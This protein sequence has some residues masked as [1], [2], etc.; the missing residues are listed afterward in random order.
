[1]KLLNLQSMQGRSVLAAVIFSALVTSAAWIAQSRVNQAE[2]QGFQNNSIQQVIDPLFSH[3]R[4]KFTKSMAYLQEFLLLPVPETR[5]KT[6]GLLQEILDHKGLARLHQSKRIDDYP[7]T[8]NHLEDIKVDLGLLIKEVTNLMDVRVDV[9]RLYPATD[10]NVSGLLPAN[11]KFRTNASLAIN[12]ATDGGGMTGNRKVYQ[13]FVDVR[14]AWRSMTGAYRLYVSNRS[15]LFGDPLS[16]MRIQKINITTYADT[17]QQMLDMLTTMD[18]AGELEFQQSDA[19]V[20]MKEAYQ[21]WF[22]HYSKTIPIYESDQWRTDIA[23]LRNSIQPLTD[24]IRGHFTAIEKD[25]GQATMSEL[26]SVSAIARS[27]SESIWIIV[28]ISIIAIAAGLIAIE[29][30]LRRPV[31]RVVQ[32]LKE[33]SRADTEDIDQTSETFVDSNTEEARELIAAFREMKS[34]VNSRQTR[35]HTILENAAEA[36]V[37][38]NELGIIESFNV[39]AEK[40]FGYQS[41]EVIGN[42]IDLLMTPD[43]GKQHHQFLQRYISKGMP[44]VIDRERELTAKHKDGSVLQISLKISEMRLEGRRLFNALMVDISERKQMLEL[45]QSRQKYLETILDNAAEGI[46]TFNEDGIIKSCNRAAEN[47]FGYRSQE[48]VNQNLSEIIPPDGRD[49]RDDYVEHFIRTKVQS[50]LGHEGEVLGRTQNGRRF[51]MAI[52]ISRIMLDNDPLYIGLISDISERKAIL[53]NLRKM[54]EYDGLTGLHN[55]SYFQEEL[56]QAVDRAKHGKHFSANLLYIDLDN[57]KYVNDTMG[58]AAGDQLLVE[59]ASM[60]NKRVRKADIVAR[61]GGDEFTVLLYDSDP[62]AA[63]AIAESFRQSMDEYRFMYRGT[64]VDIGCTIGVAS[65]DASCRNG[66]YAVSRADLACNIA[67]RAGRNRVRV[68]SPEDDASVA[69]LSVD[70]GWSAMI[71]E[72]L[73]HDKF[74]LFAQPIVSTSNM[75]TNSYEIL[76]R[77]IDGNGDQIMPAGFIPSAERFGLME[78]IDRWVIKNSIEALAKYRHYNPDLRFTINLSGQ[79]LTDISTCDLI[80]ACVEQAGVDFSNITFEVTETTAIADMS[81]AEVFLSRLQSLGCKTALDDFGTGM[82]SFAYLKDLP[83]DVVKIDGRFVQKLA[84]NPVDQAM[85]KA[86]CE[87]AHALDKKVVAEFVENEASLLLLK[88]YNVDYAQG[89][90][91]GRPSSLESLFDFSESNVVNINQ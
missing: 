66:E 8:K 17:I 86:M 54:A 69:E 43:T 74:V 10:T 88:N 36:M 84:E 32:A 55:R 79:T 9:N 30:S 35:L 42:N 11:N 63:Y 1:M 3:L 20:Y 24:K 5:E 29:F 23:L 34:Q 14:D 67:K 39:A 18:N 44:N 7:V 57:F 64:S 90:H 2:Q 91:L 61:F 28:T 78:S 47:L 46:L 45:I 41:E 16:G 65:V 83:I 72:A 40:L 50:L 89:Y 13:L 31:T 15:G 21:E 12:E 26:S 87:I 4:I 71:K 37:T 19:L 6:L 85:V 53:E 49:Q 59:V 75:N 76:L 62:Q 38:A 70:M 25:I 68:Y 77:M 52:K 51:P 60:L 73:E 27:L 58:H 81:T 80:Q 56:E 48:I 82:S 22:V 33:F